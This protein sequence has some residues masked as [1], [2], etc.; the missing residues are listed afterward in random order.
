MSDLLLKWQCCGWSAELLLIY[1]NWP[2]E[3]P[4]ITLFSQLLAE[5]LLRQLIWVELLERATQNIES[6]TAAHLIHAFIL[7][8]AEQ[9]A[10]DLLQDNAA[11]AGHL[12]LSDH[13]GDDCALQIFHL[14]LQITHYLQ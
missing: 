1:T 4:L 8:A 13:Q 14:H 10:A 12:I 9:E 5:G 3:K 7:L 2:P 6:V 11:D